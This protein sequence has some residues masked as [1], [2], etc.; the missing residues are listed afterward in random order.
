M[1]KKP[2]RYDF[3]KPIK[4]IRYKSPGFDIFFYSATL[5]GLMLAI[6]FLLFIH[7]GKFEVSFELWRVL[8]CIPLI[9]IAYLFKQ[10][11][12]E[13]R[14]YPR[15]L[16]KKHRWSIEELMQMTGKNREETEHIMSHV[17][18]SCFVVDKENIL[19]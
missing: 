17:L 1:K 10:L 9:M 15:Q 5:C 12:D 7:D 11:L 4:L 2:E 19:K 18:E 14:I 3:S 13:L 6:L 8:V 16:M